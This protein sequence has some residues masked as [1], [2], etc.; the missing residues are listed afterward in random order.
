MSPRAFLAALP[1][2]AAAAP[3]L[4]ACHA[5]PESLLPERPAASAERGSAYLRGTPHAFVALGDASSFVWPSLLGELLVTHRPG[6]APYRVLNEAKADG[7]GVGTAEGGIGAWSAPAT[8]AALAHDLE[9]DAPAREERTALCLVSLR[10]VGD[11][12]GPVKSEN[13]MLGAEMGADALERLALELHA[14]GFGRVVFA[15]PIFAAGDEPERALERVALERLLARGHEF[16]AV[17][18]DLY[19]ATRRYHP[20]A[21]LPDGRALNEFGHK[22]VAEEWYRWLAGPEAREAAVESLYAR[23]FDVEAIEASHSARARALSN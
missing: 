12:R 2:V 15:T 4:A 17:G 23:D 21:Y 7:K 14:H 1:A 10:G 22:L 8:L 3:A 16:V 5:R 19:R 9:F 11:E 18:P 20:D 13:D 6:R